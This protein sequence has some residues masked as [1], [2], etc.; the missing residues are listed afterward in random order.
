MKP[1]ILPFM[2]LLIKG[3]FVYKVEL[4]FINVPFFSCK[5]SFTFLIFFVCYVLEDVIVTNR[6]LKKQS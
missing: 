2:P 4:Y 5:K 3:M 1:P 6:I